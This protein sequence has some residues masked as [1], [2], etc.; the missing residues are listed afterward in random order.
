MKKFLLVVL[1][2]ILIVCGI[3][4]IHN[5]S[6]LKQAKS[7]LSEAVLSVNEDQYDDA[8]EKL[9]TVIAAYPHSMVKAPALY[10]LADTYE[11]QERYAAAVETHRLLITHE[12]IPVNNDWLILSIIAV[13]KLYRNDLLP[14][15]EGGDEAVYRYIHTI[16]NAIDLKREQLSLSPLIQWDEKPFI[17]L[18]NN[19][20]SLK[21][22]KN[23]ILKY[24]ETELAFLYIKAKRY[25]EAA[26]I[27]SELNTNAARFGMAQIY[28]ENGKY[29]NGINLLKELTVYDTTGK[30][31]I[32]YLD[33]MY[34]YAELLFEKEYYREAI[35]IYMK[36]ISLSHN[37]KYGEFSSYKLSVYYYSSG[38]YKNAHRYVDTTM[39]NSVLLR[40]ED[41][42]LLKGYMY[43]D[44]RDYYRALK[45]FDDFAKRF[46]Q[47]QK[48][49]TAREWKLM[50][51][52][53]IKYLG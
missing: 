37:S 39:T 2:L 53:S 29:R 52:R 36:I 10:L 17:S 40:D 20:V 1:A 14:L 32:L 4:G 45:I 24:L 27:F 49:Q 11:K 6:K 26:I 46:P 35:D 30:I 41:S 16:E 47:S 51:E 43:Y 8:I 13:S 18:Q 21:L 50:C 7:D 22:D 25:E 28:L 42:Y 15:S 31:N 33:K 19:L 9:K 5:Y 23:E 3:Y 38:D 44:V 34:E 48:V 12:H